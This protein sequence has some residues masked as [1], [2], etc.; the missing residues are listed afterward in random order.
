ME[1]LFLI[2][3]YEEYLEYLH[4]RSIFIELKFLGKVS[5]DEPLPSRDR[6]GI[7]FF[8]ACHDTEEAGFPTSVA[9]HKTNFFSLIYCQRG[10]IENGITTEGKLKIC[11]R[12]NR[13]TLVRWGSHEGR[14][15]RRSA[16]D[17]SG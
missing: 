13:V 8:L 7:C 6:P 3:Y 2:F 11:D 4:D 12:K 5:P 14:S 17:S 15:I 1:N 9:P 10:T 16:R